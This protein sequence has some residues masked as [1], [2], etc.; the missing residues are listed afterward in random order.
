MTNFFSLILFLAATVG[1]GSAR[2]AAEPDTSA[3]PLLVVVETGPGAGCDADAVR[4]AIAAELH[5][6]VV[7]P[8]SSSVVAL[9]G[10]RTNTLLVSI[11]RER[12]V[13]TLRGRRDEDLTRSVAAPAERAARLRVVAW[14]AGNVARDQLATL[15][16]PEAVAAAQEAASAPVVEASAPTTPTPTPS[17]PPAFT[18]PTTVVR[19][20]SLAESPALPR[21]TFSL[22][23]GPALMF[24]EAGVNTP[25]GFRPSHG[26]SWNPAVQL[27]GHRT[28][29]EWF[30]GVA[31]DAAPGST[32]P[33]GAAAIGGAHLPIGRLGLEPSVGAGVEVFESRT[34]VFD[35]PPVSQKIARGFF[36]ATFAATFPLSRQ[37]DAIA[38]VGGHLTATTSLDG[39][40]ALTTFGLRVR[41]P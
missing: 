39:V 38:Q 7:A 14:L 36:R 3:A 24:G 23:G 4:A 6:A 34:F 13:V 29:G 40:Y 18:A 25:G 16:L 9:A 26:T 32:H 30:V 5:A 28:I 10:P 35:G 27:E 12:I 31:A 20:Q 15:V 8:T 1:G 21:W 41:L 33:F 11:D 17:S 22:L 19:A 2:A 37:L